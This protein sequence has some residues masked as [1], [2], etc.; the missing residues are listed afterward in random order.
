MTASASLL[1]QAI[2]I[3]IIGGDCLEA[4]STAYSLLQSTV[5]VYSPLRF[6]EEKVLQIL[7]DSS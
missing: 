3:A 7:I 2:A 6:P 4:V 1:A 5:A